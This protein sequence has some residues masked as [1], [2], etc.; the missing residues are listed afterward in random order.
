MPNLSDITGA[1]AVSNLGTLATAQTK[2]ANA[3]WIQI[4]VSGSGTARLGISETPTS[5]FGLPIVAGSNAGMFFPWNGDQSFY[6]LGSFNI[7]TPTGAT[8]SVGYLGA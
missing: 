6:A 4:A 5:S 1:D 2:P 8:V 7:Y 3:R